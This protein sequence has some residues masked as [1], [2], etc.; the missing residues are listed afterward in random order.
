MPVNLNWQTYAGPESRY[1]PA[2]VHEFVKNDGGE[3][4]VIHAHN[5]VHESF[6]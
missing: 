4:L 1:C 5:C 3:R 2:A 6:L